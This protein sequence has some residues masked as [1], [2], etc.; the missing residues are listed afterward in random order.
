MPS[1]RLTKLKM[2][3]IPISAG[4]IFNT[5][6]RLSKEKNR[7]ASR[8]INPTTPQ[9]GTG[10]PIKMEYGLWETVSQLMAFEIAQKLA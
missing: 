3:P 4:N 8:N 5:L 2:I 9:I 6:D 1:P 10:I 7:E